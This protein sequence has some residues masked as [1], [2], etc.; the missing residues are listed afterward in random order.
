MSDGRTSTCPACGREVAGSA[1][2]CRSCGARLA[3]PQEVA[4]KAVP[5]PKRRAWM[6]AAVFLAAALLGAGVASAILL[7]KGGSDSSQA[8][9]EGK[10]QDEATVP[11]SPP[12]EVTRSGGVTSATEESGAGGEAAGSISAGE[13]LQAGSF[14]LA[15]DAEA[16]RERLEEKGV[17]TVVVDSD[18]AQELYPGF[19]VLIAG[20]LVSRSER[21]T[22]LKRLHQNGVPSAFARALSPARSIT[23]AEVAAG[24][25][26]GSLEVTGEDRPGQDGTAKA[27]LSVTPDGREATLEVPGRSCTVGLSLLAATSVTLSYSQRHG[28]FGGGD[29]VVRPEGGSVALTLLPPE[30]DTIVVGRLR[31]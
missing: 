25:W 14:R 16:E 21:R 28:C 11:A 15:G 4:G 19:Q 17:P 29:W 26:N 6:F 18:Q 13:Y 3:A 31:R 2:F 27:Y 22:L 12:P 5:P 8:V 9:A 20:P 24:G 1:L 7:G 23:G 30:S 10:A